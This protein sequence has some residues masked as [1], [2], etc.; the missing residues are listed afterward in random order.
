MHMVDCPVF[1]L[2]D[3][4]LYSIPQQRTMYYILSLIG[5]VNEKLHYRLSLQLIECDKVWPNYL[6]LFISPPQ[7]LRRA[8]FTLFT[9][10]S[11]LIYKTT[12]T[13]I[14]KKNNN[15]VQQ[16]SASPAG[17]TE[18]LTVRELRER[19]AELERRL[20]KYKGMYIIWVGTLLTSYFRE[21]K[22]FT[23]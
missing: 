15:A 21:K 16:R 5:F 19:N 17:S 12:M 11:L 13:I 6:S 9:F 14:T 22:G 18:N 3:L 1:F 23:S 8:A 10:H 4:Y 20:R 7:D 2:I